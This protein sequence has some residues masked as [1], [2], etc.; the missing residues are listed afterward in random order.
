MADSKTKWAKLS[1]EE[2]KA[3]TQ[4]VRELFN[5]HNAIEWMHDPVENTEIINKL[6]SGE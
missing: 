6:K 2:K 1:A 3:K 5:K 4:K